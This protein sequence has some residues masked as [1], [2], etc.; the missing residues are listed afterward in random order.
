ML[1]SLL[2]LSVLL[3]SA[4]GTGAVGS[5][6]A[7]QPSPGCA[8]AES[9]IASFPS[10]QNGGRIVF[11][12]ADERLPDHPSRGE[13]MTSLDEKPQPAPAPPTALLDDLKANAGISAVRVC[14]NVRALLD[15]H[16]IP[17][18]SD[19]AYMATRGGGDLFGAA[20]LGV[21]LPSVSSDSNEAV[22]VTSMRAGPLFGGGSIEYLKRTRGGKWNVFGVLEIWAS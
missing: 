8:F 22:L 1:R 13:W 5:I 10:V 14:A 18:G 19:A 6:Q 2:A 15:R 11:T 20:V 9:Y 17:Y 3:L 4:C 16:A 7:A 12:D 21:S